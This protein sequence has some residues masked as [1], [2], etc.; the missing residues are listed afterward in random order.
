M[1]EKKNV[2]VSVVGP[3]AVGKTKFAIELAR[4]FK[5]EILSADSRQF[6]REMNIGTAKPDAEELVMA[7]HHFINSHSIEKHYSVGM[8]ESEALALL[9]DLFQRNE[10][11]IAVGGSGLFLKALWE[12]FDD[13][14][15][16]DLKLRASL[17]AE[18]QQK[19]LAGL[20]D[21][22]KSSDPSYYEKV[23]QH[24]HQRVIRAL[25]VIRSTGKSFSSFRKG[26]SHQPRFFTNLKI[27]LNM[28]RKL[29]FD[30]IDRRM[31]LMI[32][33]GLFEEAKSLVAYRHHN[34]LQTVGYSEIYRFM[35]DEYDWEEAV[36]LLKRNSRRY[37]KRQLTWFRKDEEVNWMEPNDLDKVIRLIQNQLDA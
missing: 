22:L 37:A 17:N 29:L 26:K 18:F 16:V 4:F 30:R 32:D 25:E 7:N 8:F 21:E 9:K 14:P 2:L 20:L 31:D 28:D 12:G 1:K 6:Y 10:V 13:M 36:R 23:D 34:A 11:V 27:G 24:N 5:A 19:G 35:D 3:T 33:Q 15:E